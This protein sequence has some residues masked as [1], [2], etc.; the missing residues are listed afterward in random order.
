MW[1]KFYLEYLVIDLIP[2]FEEADFDAVI[3]HEH[4][5]S[6]SLDGR[7][8]FDNRKKSSPKS[9]ARQLLLF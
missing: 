8:V 7:T 1:G 9:G 6:N 4:Q 3:A 5:I 2:S